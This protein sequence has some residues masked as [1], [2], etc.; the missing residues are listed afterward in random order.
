MYFVSFA[1]LAL[2]S[3]CGTT[4]AGQLA[5]REVETPPAP[6]NPGLDFLTTFNV[7]LG[8][9]INLGVGPHGDRDV[10]PLTGGTAAGPKL[11]GTVLPIG[12][13]WLWRDNVGVLHPDVRAMVRTDDGVDIYVTGSGSGLSGLPLHETLFFETAS[14]EY[15][16]LNN[17]ITVAV[18]N[19]ETTWITVDVWYVPGSVI[20]LV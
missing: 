7:T 14:P 9:P 13:D 15:W 18:G 2:L 20:T 16:W 6:S 8:A 5:S 11:N 19:I 3:S 4:T 1:L 12:A 17:I 10:I